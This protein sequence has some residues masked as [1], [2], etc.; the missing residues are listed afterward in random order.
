[1]SCGLDICYCQSNFIIY[2]LSLIHIFATT[3][4][5]DGEAETGPLATSWQSN[6]VLKDVY[7][8]QH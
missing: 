6:K 2:N 5:G 1:M 4:V 8:R 7:K 3:V